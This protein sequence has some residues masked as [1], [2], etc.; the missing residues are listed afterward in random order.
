MFIFKE[1]VDGRDLAPFFFPHFFKRSQEEP[2]Q[3]FCPLH[4]LS[5]I[6]YAISFVF[7]LLGMC[8]FFE[9]S[10][11]ICYLGMIII[12]FLVLIDKLEFGTSQFTSFKAIG[13]S[14]IQCICISLTLL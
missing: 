11:L 4:S 10:T 2:H 3:L 8:C 14:N 12:V 1:V 9:Q 5:H 13:Y 7:S 6:C